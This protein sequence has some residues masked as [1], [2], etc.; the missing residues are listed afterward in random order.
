MLKFTI[1]FLKRGNEI[2]MLNREFP[3]WMGVWNG[4]GGK[5][6]DGET[7]LECILREVNEETGI[8]LKDKQVTYK[9]NITWTDPENTYYG[10]MYAFVAELPNNF[11]YDTPIKTEE[12]ILD[13]KDISWLLHPENRG[14]ADLS[15]HLAT[16]LHD[17]SCYEHQL[18]Y[19]NDKVVQCSKTPLKQFVGK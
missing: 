5:I 11:T 17:E 4:V 7:P 13:W 18:T 10:G 9:G 15:Y 19:A 2:L 16:L 6:D 1:C 12:G 8:T 14:V 3:E